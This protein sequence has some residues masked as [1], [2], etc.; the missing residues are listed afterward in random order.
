MAEVS[1]YRKAFSKSSVFIQASGVYELE[2]LQPHVCE[3]E[4]LCENFSRR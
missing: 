1:A 3:S 2:S 4:Y